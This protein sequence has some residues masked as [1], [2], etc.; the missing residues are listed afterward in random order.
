M[1]GLA[2][3]MNTI[4]KRFCSRVKSTRKLPIVL[5]VFTV[6]VLSS[7]FRPY[8]EN[9]PAAIDKWYLDELAAL[10]KKLALL[11]QG[12]TTGLKKAELKKSFLDARQA[13]KRLSVLTDYFNIYESKNINGPALPRVEEDNP[14]NIIEPHGFQVLE[15]MIYAPKP[16][17]EGIY[18]ET[19]L[20]LQTIGK[21]ENEADRIYKFRDAPVWDAL[22]SAILRIMTLGMAGFDSP[23]AQH[24]IEESKAVLEAVRELSAIYQLD[25][26]VRTDLDQ[27]IENAISY[28]NVHPGIKKFNQLEFIRDKL[29]PLYGS[30][31]KAAAAAGYTLPKERRPVHVNDTSVF[32]PRFFDVSFFSPNVRYAMTA[33]RVELGKQLF[34][35]PL[36]SGNNKQSCASCHRP[37]KAF[38][39]GHRQALG[40]DGH[41][42]LSRNTPTLLN[43]ALQTR[44][45]YD[46]RVATLEN[47]LS[48]VVHNEN[49]MQGSLKKSIDDLD[50]IPVYRTLFKKAYPDEKPSISEYT[51]ANAISSYVRSLVNFNTRF[52][53]YMRG[54]NNQLTGEEQK[55]FNVFMGKGKCGTCHFL[56][57]F[58]G[59]VPPDFNET[60]SEVLGIPSLHNRKQPDTD[61][62]KFD[63][64]R[65][66]IHRFSF[67]TPTLRNVELTAPYMHNGIFKTLEEV[68]NFYNKG[69]GNGRG[70]HIKNQTLPSDKLHLTSK[71]KKQV[72]AFLKSLTDTNR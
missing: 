13:Y 33:E 26:T 66:E 31:V 25:A 67:K 23:L 65:A 52:D 46:S 12:S 50:A 30:V 60:E 41:T 49:E 37:E 47:Q 10:K 15:E 29:D 16:D 59:L 14:N 64:T 71:E 36:L 54:E 20:M 34:S 40:I 55:G 11:Q 39:D 5:S 24:G 53:R 22:R 43:S 45:F 44:Q 35:D 1:P 19:G 63:F 42:A 28:L 32:S 4:F 21:L 17:I 51:I 6:L 3:R 7:Y 68:V 2:F 61:Q 58:N 69:G 57:L 62:G 38:T 8:A 9:N 18:A 72:I 27:K 48:A 70:F 56:P